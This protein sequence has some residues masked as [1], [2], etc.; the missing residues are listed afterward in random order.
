M[1]F[2]NAPS[3]PDAVDCTEMSTSVGRVNGFRVGYFVIGMT[4]LVRDSN[5]PSKKSL[6]AAGLSVY[7]ILGW[8]RPYCFRD[9]HILTQGQPHNFS[10]LKYS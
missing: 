7:I 2:A 4:S 9:S 6:S 10:F 3:M 5:V 8:D 1:I